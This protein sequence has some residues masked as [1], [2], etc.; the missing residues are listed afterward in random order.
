MSEISEC[1]KISA[2][3]TVNSYWLHNYF[4]QDKLILSSTSLSSF[5]NLVV[6]IKFT[7]R[8]LHF[9]KFGACELSLT[10]F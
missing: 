5:L 1:P 2:L 9:E 4:E 6:L 7:E 3:E 10:S 8:K